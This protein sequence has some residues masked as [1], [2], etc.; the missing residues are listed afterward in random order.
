MVARVRR[1]TPLCAPWIGRMR[2]EAECSLS[3]SPLPGGIDEG[4]GPGQHHESTQ[5]L[6]HADDAERAGD[7]DLGI[8]ERGEIDPGVIDHRF[9]SRLEIAGKSTHARPVDKDD[10]GA[11]EEQD[12]NGVDDQQAEK[13]AD[14]RR[15]RANEVAAGQAVQ[16]PQCH[17]VEN[18]QH[19][20]QQHPGH[21]R[22]SI[23]PSGIAAGWRGRRTARARSP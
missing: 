6:H 21:Q 7:L 23:V 4:R 10:I 20:D 8:A 15:V 2:S 13:D 12:L 14:H 18:A 17:V 11:G 16:C 19:T 22:H 1:E 9:P 3:E 5:R